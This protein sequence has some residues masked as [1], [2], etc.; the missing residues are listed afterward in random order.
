VYTAIRGS[1]KA[2]CFRVRKQQQ[3]RL[4]VSDAARQY[5]TIDAQVWSELASSKPNRSGKEERST[6]YW[7]NT[8]KVLI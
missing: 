5:M 7:C 6:C 8:C 1:S 4:P 3:W 2:L